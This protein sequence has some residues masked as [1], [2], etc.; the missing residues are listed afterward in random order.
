[1]DKLKELE[2]D[3]NTIIIFYSDNGGM[4][5]ANF[6]NPNRKV[7]ASKLDKAFSTSNLPLRGAK[8]W[9]YEGGIR[10][11]LIVRWSELKHRGAVSDVP[12]TSTDLFPTILEMIGL[13]QQPEQHADGISMVPALKEEGTSERPI[14][15]H[16][17]HY[18]NHGMQSPGGAVRYGDYKLIEYYENNTVQL[19]NLANDLEEEN[20][21]SA[22]EPAKVGELR[23][24]LHSWRDA[25]SAQMMPP[26]PGYDPA[27]V[28]GENKKP[29]AALSPA[30]RR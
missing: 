30:R 18:S 14:Y 1:M 20:D 25:V 4:S 5:G 19:F 8:G 9:L 12:V 22:K 15:W 27:A 29:T 28:A 16:F 10:V 13:P 11:P 23:E 17:P 24:M 2:L 26:N 21:L 6:G 3:D 7:D